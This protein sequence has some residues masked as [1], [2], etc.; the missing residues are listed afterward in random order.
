MNELEKITVK[1]HKHLEEDA[2]EGMMYFTLEDVHKCMKEYYESKSDSISDVSN[3][4][5]VDESK[6]VNVKVMEENTHC[7]FCGQM[8]LKDWACKPYIDSRM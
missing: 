5:T 1:Y 8:H 6:F 3:R 4:I 2:E 7:E